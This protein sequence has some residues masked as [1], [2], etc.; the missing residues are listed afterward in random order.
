MLQTLGKC[1]HACS[2]DAELDSVYDPVPHINFGVGHVLLSH[3]IEQQQSLALRAPSPTNYSQQQLEDA[4]VISTMLE[5]AG[6]EPVPPVAAAAAAAAAPSDHQEAA[7]AAR[8]FAGSRAYAGSGRQGT[9]VSPAGPGRLKQVKD[10]IIEQQQAAAAATSQA[11][12]E[13]AARAAAEAEAKKKPY[14]YVH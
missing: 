5:A 12:L 4:K 8:Q 11:R 2:S 1:L 7:Q 10:K 3:R 14:K 9:G 13:A 6:F